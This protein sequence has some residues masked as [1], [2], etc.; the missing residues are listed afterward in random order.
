[1][2]CGLCYALTLLLWF[3]F[4]LVWPHLGCQWTAKVTRVVFERSQWKRSPSVRSTLSFFFCPIPC[5]SLFFCHLLFSLCLSLS[6]F[7][8]VIRSLSEFSLRWL[9]CSP[10]THHKHQT[11]GKTKCLSTTF[12]PAMSLLNPRSGATLYDPWPLFVI[13]RAT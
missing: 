3:S 9:L 7:D 6:L 10:C 2:V 1:M 8:C 13:H 4:G 12:V 5:L 11:E